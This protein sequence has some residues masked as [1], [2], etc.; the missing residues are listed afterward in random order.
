MQVPAVAGGDGKVEF[1]RDSLSPGELT[2]PACLEIDSRAFIESRR[3]GP[4]E[5]HADSVVAGDKRQ[6]V[7]EP[8]GGRNIVDDGQ[9]RTDT[10]ACHPST[11]GSRSTTIG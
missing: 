11:G 4:C 1:D 9:N 6:N 2:N 3:A 8:G 10:D 7:E 5:H